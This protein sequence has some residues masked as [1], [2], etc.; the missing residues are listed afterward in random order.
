MISILMDN[1]IKMNKIIISLKHFIFFKWLFVKDDED[2][3]N[4]NNSKICKHK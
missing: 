1:N 4:I 3:D 2:L